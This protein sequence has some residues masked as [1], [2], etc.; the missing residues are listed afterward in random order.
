[1]LAG[2]TVVLTSV[3][4]QA[5]AEPQIKAHQPV[6]KGSR[7]PARITGAACSSDACSSDAWPNHDRNCQ[8]DRRQAANDLRTV[9]VIAL[10]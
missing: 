7:I 3:A 1:M 5:S 9:R 10:R 8:F 2:L 6:A 4:P